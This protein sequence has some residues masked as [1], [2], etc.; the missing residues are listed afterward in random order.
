MRNVLHFQK[1]SNS[2]GYFHGIIEGM[3]YSLLSTAVDVYGEVD[4]GRIRPSRFY[5]ID[6]RF[7]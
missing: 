1:L 3:N 6:Q 2:S 4:K 7:L 5:F